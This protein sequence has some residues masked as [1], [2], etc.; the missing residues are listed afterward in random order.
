[1]PPG[2]AGALADAIADVLALPADERAAMGRAARRWAE[3][4]CNGRVE[5]ERLAGL[6]QDAASSSR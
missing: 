6:I 1:V 4:H 3:E 5:A 2:D